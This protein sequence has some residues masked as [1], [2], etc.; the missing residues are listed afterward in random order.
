MSIQYVIV[1][2]DIN[3]GNNPGEKYLAQMVREQP[4]DLDLIAEQIAGASTMSKADVMGVLQQLQVEMSYHLTRGASVRL[5]LLGTFTPYLRSKAQ[6]DVDEVKAS[7]IKG[8]HITFRPSSW[9]SVKIKSASFNLIDPNIKGLVE[10]SRTNTNETS[11]TNTDSATMDALLEQ[12]EE[13][14]KKKKDNK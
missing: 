4:V 3:V 6:L 9:L 14:D 12:R 10:V 2:R 8:L 13:Q 5:G 1:K 7:T 11:T